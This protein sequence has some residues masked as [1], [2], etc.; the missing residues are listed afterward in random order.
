MAIDDLVED[1]QAALDDVEVAVGDGVERAGKTA[2]DRRSAGFSSALLAVAA[3]EAEPV[4]A[5]PAPRGCARGALLSPGARACGSAR[6]P[7]RRPRPGARCRPALEQRL[8]ERRSRRAGRGRR[9]RSARPRRRSAGSATRASCRKTCDLAARR[10]AARSVRRDGARPRRR[11]RRRRAPPARAP[12]ESASRPTPPLPA[13]ASRKRQPGDARAPG[14]RTASAARARRWAASSRPAG[15]FSRRPLPAPG[16]DARHPI[17]PAPGRSGA[18]SRRSRGSARS[19]AARGA[20][21]RRD[22]RKA[23]R[24][25]LLQQ[26]A[27]AQQV[28]PRGS[29]G[30]P[31]WRVPKKSPGPAQLQVLLRDHEAVVGLRPSPRAARAPPRRAG[32]GSRSTQVD[33][34]R[35]AAHAAAQLVELG[36]AEALGVLDHHQRRVGHVDADLDHGGRHQH[37]RS[38]RAAKAAITASFSALFMPPVQQADAHAGQRL[39]PI[40]RAICGGR[41]ARP[42]ASPTPRPAGRRRRPGGPPATSARTRLD[43]PRAG[44]TPGAWRGAIG[45]RPGGRS[46]THRDV[47][48]AVGGERQR[49]RDRR[50]RHHQHVGVVALAPQLVALQ[51]AEAVLLV[52]HRQARAAGS[53][54]PPG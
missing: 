32:R 14:C 27:V 46:S 45:V 22:Q 10:R 43:A 17:R 11:A 2:S 36:Q 47:E 39:P 26:V 54:R 4:V 38:R 53:A 40:P 18:P 50:G 37:L 8:V 44:R 31:H 13:N 52:H 20:P 48:V 34:R 9:R 28:A 51:H 41:A 24:A 25:R 42:R 15:A 35:A 12:R 6:P 19:A 23:S 5:R 3:V 33:A 7:P 21:R 16:D 49:A 30:R 29:S 1:G